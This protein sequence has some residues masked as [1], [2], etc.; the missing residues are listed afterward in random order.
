MRN[1]VALDGVTG[2]LYRKGFT[3]RGIGDKVEVWVAHARRTRTVGGVTAIGTRFPE[4]DCRNGARTEI[5]DAQVQMLVR[6]FDTNMYPKESA[7]FS[8]PPA[9]TV[10]TARRRPS[11]RW[12]RA[13]TSSC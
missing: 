13:T 11:T 5:T 7:A 6:E 9:G 2:R 8:V 4:G 3:F 1:W 10:R 12:A